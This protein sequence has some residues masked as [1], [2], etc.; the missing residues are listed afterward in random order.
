MKSL[1]FNT[2]ILYILLPPLLYVFS[3]QSIETHLKEKYSREIE[4]VYT[5][6]TGP[7]FDGSIKLNDA[8]NN[9]I[10]L[11]LQ[12]KALI[13]WG[14]KL[15]ITVVTR[16]GKILYPMFFEDKNASL[17]QS[18]SIKIAAD[19]YKIMTEGTS[20]RIDL[21]VEH[22]TLL[23]N[24][25][26]GFYVFLS[27][28]AFYFYYK[29]NIKKIKLQHLEKDQEIT[30]LMGLEKERTHKLKTLDKERKN[31]TSESQKIKKMFENEKNR[32]SKNEDEMIEE[33]ISLEKKINDNID[34]QKEQENEINAL[35]EKIQS[36]EKGKRKDKKKDSDASRIRKRFDTLYK[37]ISVHDRAIKGFIG[38]AED[39]KIKGEEIIHQL[40]EAPEMISI[41]RKVFGK[42]GRETV[43]EV[44]FA[45]KG[46]LYFRKT[47]EQS[48]E[49]LAIGS[50]NTQLKDL[51]F[52]DNR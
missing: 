51:E 52:L 4:Q 7:L 30:R 12:S 36:F 1:S 23:S 8:I 41:K 42:K 15:N 25:I 5:G 50:K 27:L 34:L 19:N 38:L 29:S 20:V 13:S 21:K 2:L 44:I 28:I 3:L 11:Y 9:N 43:L 39:L 26:L 33:I 32:A 24:T 31:L 46:R 16:H 47:K 14:V 49:I 22:N 17:M 35:K 37:N 40:N 10:N 6:D 48:I 45:Y 18:D